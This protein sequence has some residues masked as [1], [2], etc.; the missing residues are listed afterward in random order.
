METF[1]ALLLLNKQRPS[2]EVKQVASRR[3]ADLEV[4]I[5]E[6]RGMATTLRGLVHSCHGDDRPDCP[7]LA[8]LGGERR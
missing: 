4:R 2:R 7:I 5:E 8:D 1:T 3:L 6:L